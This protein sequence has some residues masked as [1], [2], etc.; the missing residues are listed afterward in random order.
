M[1]QEKGTL[2]SIKG[3]KKNMLKTT[4]GNKPTQINPKRDKKQEKDP[5]PKS[6]EKG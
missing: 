6:I 3:K 2:D 4:K 5:E 1:K